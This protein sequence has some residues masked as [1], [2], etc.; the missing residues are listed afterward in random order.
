VRRL[1]L[2]RIRVCTRCGRGGAEFKAEDGGRLVVR[3]EPARAVELRGES[4]NDEMRWLTDIV[5]AQLEAS[6]Q[7]VREV[8]LDVVDGVMRAF[9]TLAKADD[10]PAEPEVVGCTPE[11][12]V[13]VALRGGLRLFATD[14]AFAAPRGRS[15]PRD[16]GG[17][18]G[19]TLH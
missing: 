17:A 13:A 18:G 16:E 11:E 12:G 6:G 7:S 9:L 1:A 5:L 14:D 8:V 2:V 10:A 3:L 15:E 4:K 19:G